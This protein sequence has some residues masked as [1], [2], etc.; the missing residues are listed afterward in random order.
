M[1]QMK[2]ELYSY[3]DE[4]LHLVKFNIYNLCP[5]LKRET[6]SSVF[7]LVFLSPPLPVMILQISL[8]SLSFPRSLPATDSCRFSG[9][10][11]MKR[12]WLQL[13]I[14][15]FACLSF[16]FLIKR[17]L[18]FLHWFLFLNHF[19]KWV[20]SEML[21]LFKYKSQEWITTEVCVNFCETHFRVWFRSMLSLLFRVDISVDISVDTSVDT[22]VKQSS[23]QITFWAFQ[24]ILSLYSIHRH[25]DSLLQHERNSFCSQK[26]EMSLSETRLK[27]NLCFW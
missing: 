15:I 20:W 13:P 16:I 2:Q 26:R 5:I 14:F 1:L 25:L 19:V 11:K 18:F 22:S 23:F 3:T 27:G 6:Y 8:T 9:L 12:G 21:H 7:F 17:L 4:I 10:N 24:F